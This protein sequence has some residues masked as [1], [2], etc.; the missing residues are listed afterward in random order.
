MGDHKF[1]GLSK[2]ISCGQV[3]KV[4]DGGIELFNPNEVIELEG[5]EA[6]VTQ[7]ILDRRWS[8]LNEILNYSNSAI[9]HERF[10]H[11]DRQSLRNIH[12]WLITRKL[13]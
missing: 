6:E 7:A 8:N 12:Q 9:D 5:V 4:V 10:V 13:V 11:I 3:Q 2:F 1:L